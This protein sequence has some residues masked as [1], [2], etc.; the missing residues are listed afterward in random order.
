MYDNNTF[1]LQTIF[2]SAS[3]SGT[4]CQLTFGRQGKLLIRHI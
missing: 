4:L 1:C 2:L 3:L